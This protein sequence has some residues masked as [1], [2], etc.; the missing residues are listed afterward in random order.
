LNDDALTIDTD[1][2]SEHDNERAELD[3]L[4]YGECVAEWLTSFEGG[5]LVAGERVA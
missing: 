3:A 2:R 1:E 4:S 5:G